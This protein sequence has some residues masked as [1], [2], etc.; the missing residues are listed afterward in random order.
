MARTPR[1][2]NSASGIPNDGRNPSFTR[3][4][5][6]QHAKDIRGA[7]VAIVG[8]IRVSPTSMNSQKASAAGDWKVTSSGKTDPSPRHQRTPRTTNDGYGRPATRRIP[9]TRTRQAASKRPN[10]KAG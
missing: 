1:E 6:G 5:F 7:P 8:T 4:A 3:Q 9:V 10:G 2:A